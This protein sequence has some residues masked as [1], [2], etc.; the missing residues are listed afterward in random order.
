MIEQKQSVIFPIISKSIVRSVT[1][2]IKFNKDY[3][4]NK[5]KQLCYCN[6]SSYRES[7]IN[8]IYTSFEHD[9]DVS[10]SDHLIKILKNLKP[11]S[12]YVCN[13]SEFWRL[14]NSL[15]RFTH[16]KSFFSTCNVTVVAT[17]S[18]LLT[19]ILS[20]KLLYAAEMVEGIE[21]YLFNL[22]KSP[23]QDLSDLLDMKYGLI[24]LVQYKIFPLMLGYRDDNVKHGLYFGGFSNPPLEYNNEIE[25]LMELPIKTNIISDVYDY[26]IKKG[27]NTFN[28]YAEYVAGLKIEEVNNVPKKEDS[29]QMVGIHS[30]KEINSEAIKILKDSQK[31]SKGHVLDG[32]VTSPITKNETIS[33]YIPFSSSDMTKFTL[34]EYLY[35]MRV[36]ANSIKKKNCNLKCNGITLNIN[37]PFKSIT[38]PGTYSTK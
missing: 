35:M 8:S 10:D 24:N 6:N 7:L 11:Q 34:L 36:M 17:L 22:Q 37:S 19:L 28:N 18:T 4:N 16:S 27:V 30:P 29:K 32:S 12:I 25:K 14:Y 1:E 5:A 13:S 3:I 21:E 9:I 26:L 31:Y 15:Y 2:N 20:N 38:I 23:L 33:N